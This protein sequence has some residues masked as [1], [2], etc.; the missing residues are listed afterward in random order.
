MTGT[1]VHRLI[2]AAF[3]HL[4]AKLTGAPAE[5]VQQPEEQQIVQNV[6]APA[7]APNDEE[8]A[9]E[10][11]TE[12]M[13]QAMHMSEVENAAHKKQQEKPMHQ[14]CSKDFQEHF[15]HSII[16]PEVS[17]TQYCDYCLNM[18]KSLNQ[19]LP[20]YEF[21]QHHCVALQSC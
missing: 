20:R 3:E 2:E 19:M 16:L 10:Q 6:A 17:S 12:Q 9:F 14:W 4:V 15:P 8:E 7:G 11:E 1:N 18:N 21:S 13:R 5:E